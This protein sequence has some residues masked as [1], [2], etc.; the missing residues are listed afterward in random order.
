MVSDDDL[1]PFQT[2]G[3]FGWSLP[4]MAILFSSSVVGYAFA[5]FWVTQFGPLPAE[6]ARRVAGYFALVG[7]AIGVVLP[8]S[9]RLP[10]PLKLL[11]GLI[12]G[13]AGGAI[14]WR[15]MTLVSHY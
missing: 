1:G 14:G 4:T 5:L 3:D 12:A 11:L 6:G 2:G 13:A 15:L 10:W 9:T 8:L 7:V